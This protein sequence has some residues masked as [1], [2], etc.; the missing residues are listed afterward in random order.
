MQVENAGTSSAAGPIVSTR[1]RRR[2]R[3][4]QKHNMA[5]T[6][7]SEANTISGTPVVSQGLPSQPIGVQGGRQNEKFNNTFLYISLEFL[8]EYIFRDNCNNNENDT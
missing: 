8:K 1:P 5:A 2:G 7:Q 3:G 4:P 6:G